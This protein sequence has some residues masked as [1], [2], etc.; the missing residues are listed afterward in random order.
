MNCYVCARDS[1]LTPAVAICK[2]CGVALCMVHLAE[3][4][5]SR[6]GGTE[7]GWPHVLPEPKDVRTNTTAAR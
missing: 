1:L 4:Q 3:M 6:P 2:N 7:P 5:A